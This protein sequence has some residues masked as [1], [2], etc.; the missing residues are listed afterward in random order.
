MLLQ[1]SEESNKENLLL[2]LRENTTVNAQSDLK[3]SSKMNKDVMAKCKIVE[4]SR[5][6]IKQQRLQYD[7]TKSIQDLI[8]EVDS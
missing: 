3:E 8:T 6:K 5:N 4:F 2:A 1:S 7:V